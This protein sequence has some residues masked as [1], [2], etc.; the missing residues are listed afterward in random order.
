MSELIGNFFCPKCQK[1]VP[2]WHQHAKWIIPSMQWRFKNNKW[3]F[4]VN[5]I[6]P[7]MHMTGLEKDNWSVFGTL[8]DWNNIKHWE[9][10]KCA[11]IEKSFVG[12]IKNYPNCLSKYDPTIPDNG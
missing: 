9:C 3:S 6:F 8:D 11:H 7:N 2:V 1:D 5:F 12:F 10:E 4:K